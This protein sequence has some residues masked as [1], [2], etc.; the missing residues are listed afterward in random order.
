MHDPE[1][2]VR[3]ADVDKKGRSAS[4]PT[5]NS[6][7]ARGPTIASP[8]VLPPTIPSNEGVDKDPA[9]VPDHQA[10]NTLVERAAV[11]ASATRKTNPT[12]GGLQVGGVSSWTLGL[13]TERWLRGCWQSRTAHY[14]SGRCAHTRLLRLPSCHFPMDQ[15]LFRQRR[16]NPSTSMARSSSLKESCSAFPLS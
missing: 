2:K 3:A 1:E 5:S 9:A 11:N 10:E 12:A 6:S 15:T 8:A 7:S 13:W 4:C 16:D 14:T